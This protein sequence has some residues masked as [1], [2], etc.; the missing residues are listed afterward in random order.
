[1]ANNDVD[2][3]YVDSDLEAR[4][5]FA[6]IAEPCN[7]VINATIRDLGAKNALAYFG[8]II[9]QK[10][11]SNIDG[12]VLTTYR[13]AK[14]AEKSGTEFH[15]HNPNEH[16][17]K[18][19]LYIESRLGMIDLKRDLHATQSIESLIITPESDSWPRKLDDLGLDKPYCLWARGSINAFNYASE[20]SVSIVGTRNA[21][22]QARVNAQKL[23]QELRKQG[24]AIVSGGTFGIDTAAHK[25]AIGSRNVA[26]FAGGLDSLYPS[27]NSDL[28]A[29]ILKHGGAFVSE[30][31]PLASPTRSRFL[32]R[33]R[34]I[35]AMGNAV[36]VVEAPYRSGALSTAS[37]ALK[38]GRPLGAFAGNSENPACVGSNDLL[39]TGKASLVLSTSDV[40]KLAGDAEE[41]TSPKAKHNN[42]DNLY[43]ET[44]DTSN[45]ADVVLDENVHTQNTQVQQQSIERSR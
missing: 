26:V 15:V 41:L 34:L 7:H 35:A 5:V 39:R 33:N 14:K 19:A 38:L 22:Y 37:T 21:T 18:T 42:F 2:K 36:V 4:V 11:T 40:I 20:K 45:M 31:A 17:G 8:D 1:M 28:Y 6:R 27:A 29:E 13:N 9:Q 24:Y 10:Q 16:L 3:L 25:G 44:F 32:N 23:S 12:S 43:L 30:T